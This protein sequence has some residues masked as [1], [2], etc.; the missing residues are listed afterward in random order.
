MAAANGRE[1][2]GLSEDLLRAPYRFNFFQAVRVLER[3]ASEQARTA[4]HRRRSP[5]GRDQAPD[6]EVVRFRGLPSLSFPAAAV[7]QIEPRPAATPNR[8]APPPEMTVTF[9]GLTGPQ[10]VLPQHYTSL[11]LR[12]ARLKDYAL[13]DFLDQLNHRAVSLF[14]RAWEKYHW[15]IAYER[16]RF[17][18]T[19][20]DVDPCTWCLYCLVGLGTGGLRGRLEVA[21]EAFLYYSGHFAHFPRTAVSLEDMLGDYFDLPVRVQQAQGQWLT[22]EANDRSLLPGPEHPQGLNGQLGV[23][24]I[25]GERIWD[26]QSK[27]RLRVGPLTYEQFCGLMPGGS[28]LRALGQMTR[29]YVGPDLDFDVQLVLQAREVPWCRLETEGADAPRLGWN[30]W[31]RSRELP[32][33]A[34]Q[35]VFTPDGL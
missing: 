18:D 30:T 35:A 12:R 27:I 16:S 19:D 32:D 2:V 8:P 11:M 20:T 13:R 6:R 15:P 34:D 29:T 3:L 22:L 17:D 5:V 25:A 23:N 28:G 9:L 14:Y 10:G 24:T 31:V 7:S 21:D 1:S 26:V 4:G 33:D